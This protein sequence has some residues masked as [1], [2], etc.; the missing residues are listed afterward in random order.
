MSG[1]EG[2]MRENVVEN[3][4]VKAV[5]KAGGMAYK[6]NSLTTN[7]LPDRMVLFFPGKTVF[8]E[9]KAPGRQMR[10]LQAKRRHQLQQMGFPVFCIDRLTQIKPVIDAILAW[11]PG[12]PFP[13]GIG[14]KIPELDIA[15][16]PLEEDMDD[17]GEMP[18]IKEASDDISL[19]HPGY[20]C[21]DCQIGRNLGCG[22]AYGRHYDVW[23]EGLGEPD[24]CPQKTPE[25]LPF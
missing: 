11:S 23:G 9:L 1:E 8:V 10:P 20:I 16:L 12:E 19:Q 25:G 5:R 7:G 18:E 21:D 24:Y 6:L 3:E 2:M 15:R 13:E 22:H 4:F 14:A 17:G